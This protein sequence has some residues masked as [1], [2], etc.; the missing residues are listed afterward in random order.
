MMDASQAGV[1][2]GMASASAGV[3]TACVKAKQLKKGKGVG[4]P[5]HRPVLGPK[6]VEE[7]ELPNLAPMGAELESNYDW[8]E[9]F[10]YWRMYRF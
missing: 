8:S 6:A 1:G 7:Y 3:K 5:L 10:F 9:A 4:A 2:S